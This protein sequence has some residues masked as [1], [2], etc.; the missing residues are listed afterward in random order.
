[1]VARSK[2]MTSSSPGGV[3][4]YWRW[5]TPTNSL[6]SCGGSSAVSATTKEVSAFDADG[7]DNS[8]VE[9]DESLS[10][11][12]GD[13]F[14]DTQQDTTTFATEGKRRQRREQEQHN[15]R[16]KGV[17][18]QQWLPEGPWKI[19]EKQILLDVQGVKLFKFVLVSVLS[20]FLVH[21]YAILTVRKGIV[22]KNYP[23]VATANHSR[24][25]LL[26]VECGP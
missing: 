14:L 18:N 11:L 22:M 19:G 2:S 12:F 16:Q 7:R 4:R 20:L 9:E 10:L 8:S 5:M 13:S 6:E 15:D 1:M 17:W 23:I 3:H 21:Y 25:S 24:F 26:I